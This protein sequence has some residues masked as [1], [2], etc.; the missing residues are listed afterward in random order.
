M[1]K[2]AVAASLLYSFYCAA[3]YLIQRPILFPA[4]HIPAPPQP[5]FK[6]SG[7]EILWIETSDFKSEAWYLPPQP[8]SFKTL[9][10][11]I[12]F[13][14]GNG[15]LIDYNLPEMAPF[16]RFGYGVLLVEYPGYGR[17]SGKPSQKSIAQAMT[18]AYDLMVKRPDI[19]KKKIILFGRSL[20]GG[21][22]C[23][24][25]A[26]RDS[27][28]MI[29]VSTFTG[30]RSFTSSYFVPGFIVRDPFDNRSVVS[31]YNHPILIIHGKYDDTVPYHHGLELSWAAQKGTM[32]T[33]DCAH[34]DC[35]PDREQHIKNIM[36]FLQQNEI[37]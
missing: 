17:S 25:A 20:G 7:I 37:F 34:N 28:A 5:D 13:A 24:L 16:T 23:Q 33:Y 27:A 9:H 30:I 26:V 35:P 12:I 32:I 2:I 36:G 31:A 3:V 11:L 19:D 22:V 10:P 15:E 21:A 29:L 6:N 1:I 14:H 4:A 18:G 8:N